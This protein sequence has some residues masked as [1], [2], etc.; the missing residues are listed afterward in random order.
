M[1]KLDDMCCSVEICTEIIFT[2]D[3]NYKSKKRLDKFI[4]FFN[5]TSIH[6]YC[7]GIKLSSYWYAVIEYEKEIDLAFAGRSLQYIVNDDEANIMIVFIDVNDNLLIMT[8]EEFKINYLTN[9]KIF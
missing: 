5:S 3:L 6:V 7:K 1:K 9:A 2:R 8:K 4:K